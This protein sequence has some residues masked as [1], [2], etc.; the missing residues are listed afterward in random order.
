MIIEKNLN[1]VAIRSMACKE[2]SGPIT[3]THI[4]T[5]RPLLYRGVSVDEVPECGWI[6]VH[7]VARFQLRF[8]I[9][10]KHEGRNTIRRADQSRQDSSSNGHEDD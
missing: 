7:P 5:R 6:V 9:D 2:V 1:V 3:V 4:D 10:E 8:Q